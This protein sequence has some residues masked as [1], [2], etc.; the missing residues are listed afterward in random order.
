MD[1]LIGGGFWVMGDGL[2]VTRNWIISGDGGLL[3][4]ILHLI[5]DGFRI[6]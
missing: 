2:I 1:D 4:D 3:L 6:N 5:G